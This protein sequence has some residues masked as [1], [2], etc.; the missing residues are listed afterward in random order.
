MKIIKTFLCIIFG[1]IFINAGL[2]KFFNYMHIPPLEPELMKVNEA[3]GLI[4]WLIPLVG[5]F[6]I[7]GGALFIHPK[8]TALGALILF[9]IVIGIMIHTT[10][11]AP[12]SLLIPAIVFLI[13]LYALY[14][15]RNK[16]LP[17]INFK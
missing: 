6:E 11:W 14:E 12:E 13:E 1:I 7:I 8:S 17:I 4:Q 5:A 15:N 2:D 10:Y 16:Y 3:F 9:P